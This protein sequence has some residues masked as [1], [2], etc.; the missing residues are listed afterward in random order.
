MTRTQRKRTWCLVV[1]TALIAAIASGCQDD[2][3]G[4]PDVQGLAL[5]DARRELKRAGYEP[6]VQA[7]DG[8]FGVIVEENWSVCEEHSPKGRLV[9]LEVKKYGC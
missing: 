8:T 6:S 7:K 1:L 9:P 5:P 3:Q 2:L 4:A